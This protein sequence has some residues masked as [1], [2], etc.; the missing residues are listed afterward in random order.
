MKRPGLTA[1]TLALAAAG[2]HR[3]AGLLVPGG[4]AAGGGAAGVGA[5]PGGAGGVG[6]SGNGVGNGTG[7]NPGTPGY[8]VIMEPLQRQA[9]TE[10]PTPR[11]IA[12]NNVFV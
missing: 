6:G 7:M 5:A 12:A 4:G 8:R 9:T 3:Q 10:T 2:L 11:R 1:L